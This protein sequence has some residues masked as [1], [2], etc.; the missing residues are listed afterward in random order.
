[1]WFDEVLNVKSAG[2]FRKA[3]D[4]YGPRPRLEFLRIAV[5]IALAS[6]EEPDV[7][8][9]VDVKI[10]GK[11]KLDMQYD[12][13]QQRIDFMGYLLDDEIDWVPDDD[14]TGGI[15]SIDPEGDA[16]RD[17]PPVTGPGGRPP[18]APDAQRRP[19]AHT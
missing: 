14:G 17:P 6:A 9:G 18:G 4:L 3:T 2:L 5:R 16:G 12:T 13:G 1:M 11:A 19:R 15:L 7:S 10:W 8:S